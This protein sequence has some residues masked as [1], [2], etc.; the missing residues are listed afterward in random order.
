MSLIVTSANAASFRIG[1]VKKNY[2]TTFC[3]VLM[4]DSIRLST[5]RE[6]IKGMVSYSPF[7]DGKYAWINIDGQDLMLKRKSVRVINKRDKRFE[8]VGHGMIVVIE[9]KY[10]QTNYGG[11]ESEESMN[12]VT[13][14]RG[15]ESKVVHSRGVC[16]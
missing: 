10:L 5:S 6:T 4:P 1:A 9:S 15:Q 7:D 8:Y 14:K 3:G 13:F 11:M 12:K 16:V 2:K